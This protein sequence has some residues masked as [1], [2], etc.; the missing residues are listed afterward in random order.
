MFIIIFVPMNKVKLLVHRREVSIEQ[1]Q[2]VQARVIWYVPCKSYI[3]VFGCLEF[4][5]STNEIPTA[6]RYY[7]DIVSP[8]V[9]PIPATNTFRQGSWS[10][11]SD[12]SDCSHSCGGGARMR[13]RNCIAPGYCG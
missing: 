5:E 12:W 13:T 4:P 10:Q 2:V 8:Y 6:T 3:G 1:Q 7:P 9:P 11:W